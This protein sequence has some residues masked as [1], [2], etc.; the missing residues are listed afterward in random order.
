MRRTVENRTKN[1]RKLKERGKE[2]YVKGKTENWEKEK[3]NGKGVRAR[4]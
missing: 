4:E 2:R 3:R 1:E